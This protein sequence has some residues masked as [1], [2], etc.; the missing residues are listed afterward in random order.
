MTDAPY[1]RDSDTSQDAAESLSF[2]DLGRL[3]ALILV[4]IA[5]RGDGA[6]CDEIEA[7]LRLRHQTASARIRELCIRA[8]LYDTGARRPTRSRRTARVYQLTA[9]GLRHVPQ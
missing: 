1:V 8:W 7:G 6:T 2:A 9:L 4:H 5:D 3:H